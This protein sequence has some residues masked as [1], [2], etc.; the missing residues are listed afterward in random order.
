LLVQL[1]LLLGRLV[2]LLG[3]LL[4]LLHLLKRVLECLLGLFVVLLLLLLPLLVFLLLRKFIGVVVIGVRVGV[5]RTVV[6]G[7]TSGPGGACGPGSSVASGGACA[8]AEIDA[9]G[10]PATKTPSMT[11]TATAKPLTHL[12]YAR[13]RRW[14][15]RT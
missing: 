9:G 1:R 13:Y 6:A 3:F 2:L 11:A 14:L 10:I 8:C 7:L 12:I 5:V 4:G 15:C